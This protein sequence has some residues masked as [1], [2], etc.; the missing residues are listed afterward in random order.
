MSRTGSVFVDAFLNALTVA[1]VR[2]RSVAR[3]TPRIRLAV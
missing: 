2:V 3:G 1:N